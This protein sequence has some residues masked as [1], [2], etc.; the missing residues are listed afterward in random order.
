MKGANRELEKGLTGSLKRAN[1]EVEKGLT[2][3]LRTKKLTWK[4]KETVSRYRKQQQGHRKGLLESLKGLTG[5]KFRNR[6]TNLTGRLKR[7]SGRLKGLTGRLT[8][9]TGI[10]QANRDNTG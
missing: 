7:L 4:N 10:I 6:L 3:S 5:K 1:R 8:G 9:L 2:G